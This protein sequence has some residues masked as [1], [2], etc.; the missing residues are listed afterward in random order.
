MHRSTLQRTRSEPIPLPVQL[1]LQQHKML[2]N[3]QQ[4][5]HLKENHKL[6]LKKACMVISTI[7]KS[8]SLVSYAFARAFQPDEGWQK[9][10]SVLN[11]QVNGICIV[12]RI[13]AAL[14]RLVSC[15]LIVIIVSCRTSLCVLHIAEAAAPSKCQ[16]VAHGACR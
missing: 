4:D 2:L 3:K 1:L 9:L 13:T 8:A 16:E 15:S 6:Y 7:S 5:Q 10:K 11:L 14:Y 12:S